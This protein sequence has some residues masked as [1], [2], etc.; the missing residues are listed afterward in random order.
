MN[1]NFCCEKSYENDA[2]LW[3][4]DD[5]PKQSQ[6]QTG[7]LLINRMCPKKSDISQQFRKGIRGR[8]AEGT[9]IRKARQMKK[10]G[11]G[12]SCTDCS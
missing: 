7:R 4:R 3:L 6:F 5:E 8:I 12:I 9:S 10:L 1:A 2:T 11:L